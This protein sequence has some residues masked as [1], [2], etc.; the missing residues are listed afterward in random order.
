MF[1]WLHGEIYNVTIN[2]MNICQQYPTHVNH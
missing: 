1:N 2:A